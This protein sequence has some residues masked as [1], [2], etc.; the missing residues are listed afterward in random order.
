MPKIG[1]LNIK[2]GKDSL[3][4]PIDRAINCSV[5]DPP[6][7]EPIKEV[8]ATSIH[9][10]SDSN[11]EEDIEGKSGEVI[12]ANEDSNKTVELPKTEKPS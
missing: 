3:H 8:M 1:Y 5:E 10:S 9:E 7:L 2:L 6:I 11:L 12:E 4:I